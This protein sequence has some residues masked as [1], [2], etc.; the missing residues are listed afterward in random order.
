MAEE[1]KKAREELNAARSRC[2]SLQ[3]ELKKRGNQAETE[4][5]A[6]K[7]KHQRTKQTLQ[8][9]TESLEDL[10]FRFETNHRKRRAVKSA[11]D[12]LQ[13]AL[14]TAVSQNQRQ[15]AEITAVNEKNA[16]LEAQLKESRDSLLHSP[17]PSVAEREGFHSQIRTLNETNAGLDKKIAILNNDLGYCRE[18]Y[19]TAS[20]AAVEAA[21]RV[22]ELEAELAVAN[23]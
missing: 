3:D 15:S 23:R 4:L 10:Q 11:H 14:A 13:V 17:E 6:E 8:E 7:L 2:A 12:E 20:N 5:A 16:M 9:Y 21:G 22:S 19:Q 1:L 18:Q